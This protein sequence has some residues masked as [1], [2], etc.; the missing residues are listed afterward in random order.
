MLVC[1]RLKIK[2]RRYF[3][4]QHVVK[5]WNSLMQNIVDTKFYIGSREDWATMEEKSAEVFS[6]YRNYLWFKVHE[7]QLAVS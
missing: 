6:Y 4:I 2:K 7:V 5:V 1:D 3:L